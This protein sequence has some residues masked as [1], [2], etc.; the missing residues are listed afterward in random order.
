MGSVYLWGL[1]GLLPLFL[2]GLP[3]LPCDMVCHVA[4][5]ICVGLLRP[6]GGGSGGAFGGVWATVGMWSVV[7]GPSQLEEGGWVLWCTFFLSL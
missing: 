6:V 3:T 4:L 7:L 1:P 5:F 2:G